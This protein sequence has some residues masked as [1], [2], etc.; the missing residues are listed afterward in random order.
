MKKTIISPCSELQIN[1]PFPL[2]LSPWQRVCCVVICDDPPGNE[3]SI[4]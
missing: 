4:W 2:L 3:F 1:L